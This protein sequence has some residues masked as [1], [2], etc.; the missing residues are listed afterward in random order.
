MTRLEYFHESFDHKAAE[1]EGVVYP[2]EGYDEEY[3]AACKAVKETE[4]E[5]Q[6]YLRKK[7]KELGSNEVSFKDLGKE[8]F[9][10]RWLLQVVLKCASEVAKAAANPV[11]GSSQALEV[12]SS[13][14]LVQ[15]L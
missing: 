15:A 7:K 8:L 3:D 4:K 5:L 11:A 9:Q 12:F 1:K 6:E 14:K 2:H 10:V 13:L